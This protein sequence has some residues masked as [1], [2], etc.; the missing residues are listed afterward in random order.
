MIRITAANLHTDQDGNKSLVLTYRLP[1]EN[2]PHTDPVKSAQGK[3]MNDDPSY[4]QHTHF[5]PLGA[6]AVRMALYG[7]DDQHDAIESMV[8]EI[9]STPHRDPDKHPGRDDIASSKGRH[10]ITGL[11]QALR[12]AG[13]TISKPSDALLLEWEKQMLLRMGRKELARTRGVKESDLPDLSDP[14]EREK[15]LKARLA[16]NSA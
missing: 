2:V 15:P 8:H 3:S 1:D 4:G 6:I 12:D 10:T 9:I 16:R 5:I 14:V 11:K 7:L 13:L